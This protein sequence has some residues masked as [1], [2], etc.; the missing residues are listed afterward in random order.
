[1]LLCP[2]SRLHKTYHTR[3]IDDTCFLCVQ[4]LLLC[5]C[6]LVVCSFL[7]TC[8]GSFCACVRVSV[9][10]MIIF[11]SPSILP[12]VL[13]P[14]HLM[15]SDLLGWISL[16]MRLFLPLSQCPSSLSRSVYLTVTHVYFLC[17]SEFECCWWDHDDDDDD[18]NA[19]G[20][21]WFAQWNTA[22]RMNEWKCM[23][24]SNKCGRGCWI[25][26]KRLLQKFWIAEKRDGDHSSSSLS[27]W[28]RV[29]S[30]DSFSLGVFLSF[31]VRL[32][33]AVVGFLFWLLWVCFGIDKKRSEFFWHMRAEMQKTASVFASLFIFLL[34]H[35][36][37]SDVYAVLA[38]PDCYSEFEFLDLLCK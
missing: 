7:F 3:Y 15:W 25:A 34:T 18:D 12:C 27:T 28:V 17:M 23:K 10:F 30:L 4:I 8:I 35:A 1:M 9:H 31:G 20:L 14:F 22:L 2:L 38:A 37:V 5:L 11:L 32:V 16:V 29:V 26:D 21:L 13:F 33:V 6:C 36:C 24:D 19:E